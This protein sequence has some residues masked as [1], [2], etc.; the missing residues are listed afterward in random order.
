MFT[1]TDFNQIQQIPV[2]ILKTPEVDR[3]Q[4]LEE[5]L[6]NQKFFQVEL[7]KSTMA[8]TFI[9]ID[10]HFIKYE[11]EEFNLLEGRELRPSEIACANSHNL[12]RDIIANTTC[13]GI[14]LE[15]DARFLDLDY[16]Y[17]TVSSFLQNKLNEK[18]ILNLTG[19][20]GKTTS[21][22]NC[23]KIHK[24]FGAPD[25]AVGYAL[26]PS[27][28]SE[29]IRSNSPIK[30]VADWPDSKCRF[31][32]PINPPINHGDENTSSIIAKDKIDFRKTN[33]YFVIKLF[34]SRVLKPN[35]TNNRIALFMYFRYQLLRR[36]YFH[37]D[38]L[39]ISLILRMYP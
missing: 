13:G 26:T 1:K 39:M 20:Y 5:L 37:L 36:I 22:S 21:T 29:L 30:Y 11:L 12:A 31:Y 38:S 7:I 14:I 8:K 17:L 10:R 28:A 18:A 33:R 34:F 2:V 19:F 23:N 15:D 25:L 4:V 27:A 3:S 16:L 9:D 35:L 24:L 32:V 6:K